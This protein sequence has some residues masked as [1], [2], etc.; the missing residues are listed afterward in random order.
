MLSVPQLAN[1]G[2]EVGFDQ[3]GCTLTMGGVALTKAKLKEKLYKSKVTYPEAEPALQVQTQDQSRIWH[4]CLCHSGEEALRRVLK[5]DVVGGLR[6]NTF[7][8]PKGICDGYEQGKQ[9]R[10]AFPKAE[11]HRA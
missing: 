10:K 4:N 3:T 1:K 11:K 9:A 2:A 6:P 8:V 7:R 5:G